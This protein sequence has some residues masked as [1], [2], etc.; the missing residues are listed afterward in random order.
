MSRRQVAVAGQTSKKQPE[1]TKVAAGTN[2]QSFG[3]GSRKPG[4]N[5]GPKIKVIDVKNTA[6]VNVFDSVICLRRS[7]TQFTGSSFRAA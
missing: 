4:N 5:F 3:A 2:C 6:T 7:D 1:N